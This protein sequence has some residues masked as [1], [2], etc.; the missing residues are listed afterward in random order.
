M[1]E[2]AHSAD[3]ERIDPP[4]RADFERKYV[5][6]N[7]PVIIRGV[8]SRWPAFESWTPEYLQSVA[9]DVDVQAFFD[10]DSNFHRW[11]SNGQ[12]AHHPMKFG[13]LVGKLNGD[14]PDT[15]YYMVEYAL[16]R[17][18]DAFLKDLDLSEYTL[19][20][21]S[22]ATP[23]PMLFM[24]HDT[25][26]PM[27]YHTNTEALLAQ[28]HGTK[29]VTLYS[30]EQFSYLYPRPLNAPSFTFSQIDW[31]EPDAERYPK[32][33]RSKA[34]KFI[35]HP[36]EILFIPVHWWHFTTVKGFQ[37]SVTGI[38]RAQRAQYHYPYPG[39][40]AHAHEMRFQVGRLKRKLRRPFKN[41]K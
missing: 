18:S 15:R 23:S 28:L 5:K 39:L 11:Y 6:Q 30:P 24:G 20:H 37:L 26:M 7:R 17:I 4:T 1:V 3:I 22:K 12:S 29:T 41:G 13:E 27:H 38:W 19:G 16:D 35:L 36:G 40:Q 8:A 31:R 9:G 33:K 32:I 10:A 34:L 2:L 21:P 25:A 14:P